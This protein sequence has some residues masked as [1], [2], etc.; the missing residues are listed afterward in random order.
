MPDAELR[1][2]SLGVHVKPA[3]VNL[4][5]LDGRSTVVFIHAYVY[6]ILYT[7]VYIYMHICPCVYI[8]TYMDPDVYM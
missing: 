4:D 2:I 3:G 1:V 5:L 7:G 6:I 8:Y